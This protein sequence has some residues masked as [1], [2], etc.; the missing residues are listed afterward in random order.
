M[1]SLYARAWY[2]KAL[3]LL[4]LKNQIGSEKKFERALEAFDDVLEVNPDDSIA[5]QYRGNILRYLK[6]HLRLLRA[7]LKGMIS[8]LERYTTAGLL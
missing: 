6:R 3:A 7:C 2:S 5:W 8:T 4:N 1:N